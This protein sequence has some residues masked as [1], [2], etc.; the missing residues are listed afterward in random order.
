MRGA[1]D[2]VGQR[3]RRAGVAYHAFVHTCW[4]RS[5]WQTNAIPSTSTFVP[6]GPS[7]TAARAVNMQSPVSNPTFSGAGGGTSGVQVTDQE[8][9]PFCISPSNC[10]PV[11][12]P[13]SLAFSAHRLPCLSLPSVPS[14]PRFH[15]PS[16][17]PP[18]ISPSL[19]SPP[20]PLSR[21]LSLPPSFPPSLLPPLPRPPPL[22]CLPLISLVTCPSTL[23]IPFPPSLLLPPIPPS[24]S[25][26][27]SPSL[28]VPPSLPSTLPPSLLLPPSP[29]LAL[30][31]SPS[32]SLHLPPSP[33]R[34]LALSLPPSPPSHDE[35]A[36]ALHWLIHRL[37]TIK[38]LSEKPPERKEMASARGADPFFP[39]NSPTTGQQGP[40]PTRQ[41][42]HRLL[43]GWPIDRFRKIHSDSRR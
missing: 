19:P 39:A 42:G 40:T 41:P 27:P 22:R 35:A 5:M 15:H 3:P 16:A 10:S 20:R 28:S 38:R 1:C 37:I 30:P 4:R 13:P 12:R 7:R 36:A 29:S 9:Q 31:R 14:S 17:N 34:A 26:P 23:L 25:L 18:K 11:P 32:L 8:H 43:I 24:C 33:S 2:A 21:F 6:Q